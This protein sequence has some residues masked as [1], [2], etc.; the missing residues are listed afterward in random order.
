MN[1]LVHVYMY[2]CATVA[3]IYTPTNTIRPVDSRFVHHLALSGFLVVVDPSMRWC[4]IV[5]LLEFH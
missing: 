3:P 2:K 5:V 4:V 1:S